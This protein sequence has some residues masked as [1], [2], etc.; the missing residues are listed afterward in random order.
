MLPSV[1]EPLPAI[2]NAEKR[3]SAP[4][5]AWLWLNF[6]SLDAP[7]VA[8]LWQTLLDRC[9]NVAFSFETSAALVLSVWFIYV[10]DRLLDALRWRSDALAPR[11]RFYRQH[12]YPFACAAMVGLFALGWLCGRIQPLLLRN[13]FVLLGA[14]IAYFSVVHL[15]PPSLRKLWPKEI[16]VGVIFS[17]GACLPA[18]TE[19]PEARSEIVAPALL[20]ATVCVLNCMAI[21][22]WEWYH[23]QPTFGAPPHRFTCWVGHRLVPATAFVAIITVL[24]FASGPALMRPFYLASLLSCVALFCLAWRSERMPVELLRV[25][26]DVALFT[27]AIAAV[28]L[29]VR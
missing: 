12:W 1:T 11:H 21:E 18:W 24:A 13:G 7:L 5:R 14:V 29:N 3:A 9:L 17:L 26:A 25:L 2:A 16:I 15:G 8:L 27:P 22:F 20:F 23:Y 6:A 10:S 28:V 19:R 4:G